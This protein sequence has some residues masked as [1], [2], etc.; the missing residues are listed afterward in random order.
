MKNLYLILTQSIYT[1][2]LMYITVG[3]FELHHKDHVREVALEKIFESIS[4]INERIMRSMMYRYED[5]VETGVKDVFDEEKHRN[6][7]RLQNKNIE[8]ISTE[9]SNQSKLPRVDFIKHRRAK[10]TK[11]LVIDIDDID[12]EDKSLNQINL[13]LNLEDEGHTTITSC[14]LLDEDEMS[15]SHNFYSMVYDLKLELMTDRNPDQSWTLMEQNEIIF[16]SKSQNSTSLGTL[17]PHTSQSFNY[18]R[19]V[20]NGG[21]NL[22]TVKA[23]YDFRIYSEFDF[24]EQYC[25]EYGVDSFTLNVNNKTVISDRLYGRSLTTSFCVD[26]EGNLVNEE[27]KKVVSKKYPSRECTNNS[28]CICDSNPTIANFDENDEIL[29]NIK[30]NVLVK[31]TLFSSSEKLRDIETP[32]YK[33]A[34][35]IL[36]DDPFFRQQQLESSVSSRR[37]EKRMLQRYILAMFYFATAPE[38]W[39]Y[40]YHFLS[41]RSECLW[42]SRAEF[43]DNTI[44]TIRGVLCDEDDQVFSIN[45][46]KYPM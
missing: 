32:Q 11:K 13:D 4:D 18:K 34:C 28:A 36:Y 10:N 40:H 14:L 5:N 22:E 16:D 41:S 35:W 26:G 31:M 33:A 15:D 25:C 1:V 2:W 42:N 39:N 17:E 7:L 30:M 27:K 24:L 6:D 3:F 23:C 44:D 37:T 29:H 19:F 20:S 45:F 12:N 43:Y 38:Q 9:K 8:D 46:C 21:A